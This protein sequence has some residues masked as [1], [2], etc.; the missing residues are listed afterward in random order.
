MKKRILFTLSLTVFITINALFRFFIDE[1]V[2]GVNSCLIDGIFTWS[3]NRFLIIGLIPMI[4]Y[5]YFIEELNQDNNTNIIIR[6]KD[7]FEIWLEESRKILSL[8]LF[9]FLFDIFIS[10]LFSI[11]F[12]GINSNYSKLSG[13]AFL[14]HSYLGITCFEKLNT[15]VCPKL[16]IVNVVVFIV[17]NLL[18]I[19]LLVIVANAVRWLISTV[20]SYV[21]LFGFCGLIGVNFAA[22]FYGLSDLGIKSSNGDYYYEILKKD[23][24]LQK[25]FVEIVFISIAFLIVK[26]FINRKNFI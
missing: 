2:S 17:I 10:F 13:D 7:R 22:K 12:N 18:Q 4:V 15:T 24:Y 8:C 5:W 26:I 11:V 14:K 23:I 20:V 16:N 3:V 25:I 9:S 19:F 6:R 21:C 1:K